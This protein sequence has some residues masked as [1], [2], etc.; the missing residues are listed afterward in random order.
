MAPTTDEP[1]PPIDPIGDVAQRRRIVDRA[2]AFVRTA[3]IRAGQASLRIGVLTGRRR[4]VPLVSYPRSGSGLLRTY[5]SILQGRPQLSVYPGDAVV[6]EGVPLTRAARGFALVKSH[7]FEPGDGDVVY[8]VRDGR[9]AMISHLYLRFLWGGHSF[10]H[11]E[12]IFEAIRSLAEDG[13][14][15][16][17]HARRAIEESRRRRVFVVRFEELLA[18][19]AGALREI[20]A[21]LGADV[22]ESVL[23]DCVLRARDV[24][25]YFERASSGYRYEPPEHSIYAILKR[26]RPQGYWPR[27]L[28]A[29]TRRFIHE[30]GGTEPLLHFGYESSVDWWRADVTSRP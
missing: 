26:H 2:R 7:E 20:L 6:T 11:P 16:G 3:R 9:D 19:P 14:F 1:T 8:L 5:F 22:P 15:W 27:I 13:H 25:D 30:R 24:K 10:F 17:D 23:A 12:E 28:D 18:D 4:I 21:F 29:D